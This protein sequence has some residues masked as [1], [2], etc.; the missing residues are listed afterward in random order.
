MFEFAFEVLNEKRQYAARPVRKV[1]S[2]F[3]CL[4]NRS[5]VLHI[6]WQ[7]VRGD[8]TGHP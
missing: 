2:H 7:P 8:F 3:E 1:S 4:E 5:H 6:N